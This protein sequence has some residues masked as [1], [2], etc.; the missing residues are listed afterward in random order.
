MGT[1]AGPHQISVGA[2]EQ[3]HEWGGRWIR[4]AVVISAN[5]VAIISELVAQRAPS[6][7]PPP[8]RPRSRFHPFGLTKRSVWKV[9]P[10]CPTHA[11][12]QQ[13]SYQSRGDEVSVSVLV[14]LWLEVS[15]S[16]PLSV[17]V[18]IANQEVPRYPVKL[19]AFVR[20][21]V[22]P[23]HRHHRSSGQLC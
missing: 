22:R 21:F 5:N 9:L 8:S 23:D 7:R 19:R 15:R 14:R 12:A 2:K 6:P 13:G 1:R 10:Q 16:H 18:A 11:R 17:E 4:Y 20:E 3:L